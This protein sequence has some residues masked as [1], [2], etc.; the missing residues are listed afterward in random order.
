M[1]Q[2]KRIAAALVPNAAVNKIIS[3]FDLDNKLKTKD[4]NGNIRTI[5]TED[6]SGRSSARPYLVYKAL[7]TQT[8][9]SAPVATV[10]ENT[11]GGAVVWSYQGVG[12][13][14]A[15]LSGAF[16]EN[17]TIFP[18]DGKIISGDVNTLLVKAISSRTNSNVVNL[19]SYDIVNDS[20]INSELDSFLFEILVYP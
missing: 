4:E 1:I 9:T 8:G 20:A 6:T 5:V 11:L 19:Q 2:I 18:S 14:N 10:I 15:T 7:L 17:K 16:T 13:Y 3:F 12:S